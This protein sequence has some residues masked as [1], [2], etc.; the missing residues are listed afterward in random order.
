MSELRITAEAAGV[1]LHG[2]RPG[3]VHG[4]AAAAGRAL[5]E[6]TGLQPPPPP[7]APPM[8]GDTWNMWCYGNFND[9]TARLSC[10]RSDTCKSTLGSK[11][12]YETY[13][14]MRNR[15]RKFP[16]LTSCTAINWFFNWPSQALI[17]VA[18]RFLG[19]GQVVTR[20]EVARRLRLTAGDGGREYGDPDDLEHVDPQHAQRQRHN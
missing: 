14:A 7:S 15:C 5:S 4:V 1:E 18:Q 19:L 16:A 20:R 17:S 2:G 11:T 12:S 13:L 3:E 10:C 8:C 9:G 6:A